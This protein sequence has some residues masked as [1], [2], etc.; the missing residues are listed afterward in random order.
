MNAVLVLQGV[1]STL[2]VSTQKVVTDV[3]V[4]TVLHPGGK[5]VWVSWN[6]S[7]TVYL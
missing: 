2:V 3:S 4:M 7:F 6:V 5:C 1:S